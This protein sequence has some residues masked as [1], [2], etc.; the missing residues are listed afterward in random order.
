MAVIIAILA[1]VTTGVWVGMDSRVS[2]QLIGSRKLLCTAW[3]GTRV[4]FLSS[5][6]SNMASLV[7]QTMERLVADR[8]LVRPGELCFL[9]GSAVSVHCE[10]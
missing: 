8:A 7:L 4:R 1:I 3:K 9:W 5:M 2:S 10:G 6:G